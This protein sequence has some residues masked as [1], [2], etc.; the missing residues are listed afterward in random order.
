MLTGGSSLFGAMAS[1]VMYR[2]T[3]FAARDRLVPGRTPG[4][5]HSCVETRIFP[6]EPPLQRRPDKLVRRHA[7]SR[8]L[9]LD[10]VLHMSFRHAQNAAGLRRHLHRAGTFEEVDHCER[11]A[12]AAAHGQDVVVA[13]D[14]CVSCPEVRHETGPLVLVQRHALEVVVGDLA[15]QQHG[16]LVQRQQTLL[17]TCDT[18][19]GDC[20]Q[21]DDALGVRPGGVDCRVDGEAGRVHR[22][23][24]LL[25]LVPV[26]IDLDHG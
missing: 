22:V 26:Q 23:G 16:R 7:Q 10:D 4:R 11:L 2:T 9:P 3:P 15:I 6:G 25:N 17:L 19:S 13:E 8:G 24:E 20:M 5:L 14:H 18:R 12:H 1:S 21:M